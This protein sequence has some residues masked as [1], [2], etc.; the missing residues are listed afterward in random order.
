MCK[1]EVTILALV[2]PEAEIE[3]VT[4][5][6]QLQ[7]LVGL[8]VAITIIIIITR[9]NIEELVLVRIHTHVADGLP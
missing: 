9:Q 7:I 1:W 5:Q 2:Q 4:N 6:L 3:P 8:P